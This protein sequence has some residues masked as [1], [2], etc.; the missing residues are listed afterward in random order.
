MSDTASWLTAIATA[1]AAVGTV[2]ALLF[3]A[4]AARS[5]SE[6][7]DVA[8]RQFQL[9]SRP[10]LIDVPYER[11]RD[12]EH[13]YPWPSEEGF[14]G[15]SWRGTIMV[16]RAEGTFAVP[17]R[18]VG[19]GP[20]LV[21]S[22]S[23][24]LTYSGASYSQYGGIAVPVG[25]DRWLGG[26]PVIGELKDALTDDPSPTSG[27]MPIVFTVTYTDLVGQQRQRLELAVGT[28]GFGTTLRVVRIKH[29]DLDE[30]PINRLRTWPAVDGLL[31]QPVGKE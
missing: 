31:G 29:I 9:E 23:I 27:P 21:E 3:E 14:K 18:N 6:S 16:D 2:G 10:R 7:A 4:R 28:R 25:E 15:T 19:R 8:T 12:G 24:T 1:G 20:A 13:E 17:V 5:A 26:A 22:V 30:P 11:Y